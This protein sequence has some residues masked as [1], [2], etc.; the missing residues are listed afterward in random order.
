MGSGA[1]ALLP[2]FVCGDLCRAFHDMRPMY[3]GA[4]A[5][6]EEED[7]GSTRGNEAAEKGLNPEKGST[8]GAIL[9]RD[10]AVKTLQ[11]HLTEIVECV[12][13]NIKAKHMPSANLLFYL[14]TR[15]KAEEVIP[16]EEYQS[17]AEVLWEFRDDLADE[18]QEAQVIEG[19]AEWSPSDGTKQERGFESRE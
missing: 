5:E 3:G 18:I 17:L 7:S 1:G 4:M 10:M 13:V 15:L 16:E 14:A 19:K 9:L 6:E 11:E 8:G 12:V 2:I